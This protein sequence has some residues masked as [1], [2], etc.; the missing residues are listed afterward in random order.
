MGEVIIRNRGELETA[1]WDVKI[2]PGR[3]HLDAAAP[4]V[5]VQVIDDWLKNCL[6]N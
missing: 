5:Q 3:N 1:G 4:D 2:L 6:K